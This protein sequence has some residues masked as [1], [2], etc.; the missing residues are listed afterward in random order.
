MVASNV[1]KDVPSTSM[2]RKDVPRTS[3]Q[4]K[5]PPITILQGKEDTPKDATK[6]REAA[7]RVVDKVSNPFNLEA[8]IAKLKISIPLGEL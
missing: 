1:K 6:K 5:E 8:E 2:Q 7:Y 3:A 4:R